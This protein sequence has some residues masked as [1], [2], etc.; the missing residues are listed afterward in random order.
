MP[1]VNG[2]LTAVRVLVTAFVT[3]SVPVASLVGEVPP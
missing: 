1:A 3:P 2:A